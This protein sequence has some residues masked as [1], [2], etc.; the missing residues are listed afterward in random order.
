[1]D[2]KGSK[3]YFSRLDDGE[4]NLYNKISDALLNFEPALSVHAGMGKPFNVDIEKVFY[5]VIFDNPVFFYL[6]RERVAIKQSPMYIQLVFYY[7]YGRA[8][9]TELWERINDKLDSFVTE[10]I[11]DNMS[12]LAKQLEIHRYLTSISYASA[13]YSKDCFSAVGALLHRSCVCEGYAKAYKLLCDRVGIASII[14]MGDGSLPDGTSER[15]AWNITRIDG[16]TAH[17]DATWDA[18]YG[19]S[20]YDYFN[21][22]DSEILKDHSF[23]KNDYPACAPNKINYFYKNGLVA[24]NEAELRALVDLR[25]DC[26]RYSV[27]LLFDFDF[28]RIDKFPFYGGEV[29]FN[30]SQNI[31]NYFKT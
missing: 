26:E 23:N 31:I 15:H 2:I 19:V 24:H 16:V 18:R 9:A 25:S 4:K 6:N 29:R 27:K 21:L 1:M 7:D 30:R 11:K 12:P 20:N 5:G 28:S 17:T 3:Y 13:P 10:K 14:V 22:C 8:E